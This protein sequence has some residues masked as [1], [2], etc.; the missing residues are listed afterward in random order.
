MQRFSKRHGHSSAHSEISVRD[1]APEELRGVVVDIAYEAGLTPKKVRSVVCRV[2]RRRADPNNWSDFPNVDSEA[3]DYLDSCKWYEV[4]DIIEALYG[5]A[6]RSDGF[7]RT[8]PAKTFMEEINDYFE[9]RGI[10]WQLIDGE[11]QTRGEE[12]FELIVNSAK[13]QLSDSGRVSAAKELH[14]ALVDL[15]RR[16]DPDITGS[17]QHALAALECVARDS[18]KHHQEQSRA[19]SAPTRCCSEQIVGICV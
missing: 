10:G 5:A 8:E 12:A 19:D 1:D 13:S 7:G 9:R 6:E 17:I 4:Y 14:E 2:L 15:S 3:R 16:P 11:I 18:R